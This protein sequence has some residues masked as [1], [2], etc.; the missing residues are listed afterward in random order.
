MGLALDAAHNMSR[1]YSIDPER[2]YVG[3]Y[4][5]GGRTASALAVLVSEVFRGGL[6]VMGVDYFRRVPI[7]DQPGTYWPGT[8]PPPPPATLERLRRQARFVLLTGELDFN[9]AQT[10]AYFGEFQRDGFEHVTY[11]EVPGASH[12]DGPDG[13]WFARALDALDPAGS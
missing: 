2:V 7:P 9:R 8:F 1:L 12:S 3:G 13:E 10:R 4:S 5:G 6:C 11:L